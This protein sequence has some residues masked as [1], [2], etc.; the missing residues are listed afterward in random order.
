MSENI[1]QPSY[2][3]LQWKCLIENQEK[4]RTNIGALSRIANKSKSVKLR[5]SFSKRLL[6]NPT[7][8]YT[9]KKGKAKKAAAATSEKQRR[10]QK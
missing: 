6:N 10:I 7:S 2:A 8:A 1:R 3:R 5:H 4:K 9:H